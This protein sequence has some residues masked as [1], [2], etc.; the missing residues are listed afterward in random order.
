MLKSNS[1][2]Y[3]FGAG[4]FGIEVA[5]I[6]TKFGITVH[7]I[8]DNLK[9]GVAGGWKIQHPKSADPNL[10]I[11][12]GVCNLAVDLK[13]I[14]SDLKNYG[15]NEVY[16]PVH[17][18]NF[19]EE[20]GL[21]KE[22]YWLT[23][24]RSLY[25]KSRKEIDKFSGILIDDESKFLLESLINYRTK[26]DIGFL[27]DVNPVSHQYLPRDLEAVPSPMHLVD[28][29]AYVG[30]FLDYADE[31]NFKIGSYYAFEP[32]PTNYE[33][34]ISRMKNLP[35]DVPGV[36]FPLG[37]AEK[38]KQVRFS[39]NG[40]L[41]AAISEHGDTVIQVTSLDSALFNIPINYIKMDIEGAEMDALQGSLEILNRHRPNLAISAYHKPDDLWQIGLW[42][43]GLDLDYRFAIRQYGHQCFD[44]VLYAF[45]RNEEQ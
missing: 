41:G 40:T 37:V 29:G 9:T 44:T 8:L 14:E 35:L 7:G 32:D 26:G 18:F 21:E 11:A 25:D 36:S 27:P 43:D 15:F 28:C 6:L 2:V 17:L 23:T 13:L 31:R 38:P 45:A 16:T 39:A 12:L 20:N 5:T 34:L 22:H 30:E 1:S 33:K 3:V 4:S 19:F 42:L 24:N 10:P